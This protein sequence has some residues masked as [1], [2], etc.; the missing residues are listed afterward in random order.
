MPPSDKAIII[1]GNLRK[2]GVH[3]KSLSARKEFIGVMAILTSAGASSDVTVIDDEEPICM[4]TTVL[5]S[6]HA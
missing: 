5:V 4:H 6:S 2:I 3:I 1:F